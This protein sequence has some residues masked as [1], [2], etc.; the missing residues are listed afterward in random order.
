MRHGC[1]RWLLGLACAGWVAVPLAAQQREG[2]EAWNHGRHDEARA[3]YERV[4][5]TDSTAFRANLR[6]GVMLSWQGKQDS[7]LAFIARARRS[8]AG[9]SGSAAHRGQGHGVEGPPCR[10][11][12]TLRQRARGAPGSRRSRAGAGAHQRV[13]R[14]PE[15]GGARLSRGAGS[16]PAEPGRARR[17]RLRVP[18]AGPRRSGRA[19]GE[20][21]AGRRFDASGRARAAGRGA[22]RGAG[23]RPKSRPTGATTPTGTRISGRP[24]APP[25]R[26]RRGSGYSATWAR[27]RHPIPCATRLA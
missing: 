11:A 8:G 10:R 18:L 24:S 17:A 21:R 3:A 2:D 23:R 25:R 16:R 9:R 1:V 20:R 26:W 7:A 27:S 5:A 12:G 13:A 6:I 15:R 14:R 4:L 19:D 22:R